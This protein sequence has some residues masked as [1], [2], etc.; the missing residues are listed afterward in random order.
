[1]DNKL[2]FI[3]ILAPLSMA[4]FSNSGATYFAPKIRE[5]MIELEHV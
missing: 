1:M 2:K 4:A 5:V 3:K